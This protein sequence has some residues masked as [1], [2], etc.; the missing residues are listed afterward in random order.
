MMYSSAGSICAPDPPPDQ[1][2]TAY[3]SSV[4]S[5]HRKNVVPAARAGNSSN[6]AAKKRRPKGGMRA[7]ASAAG[8]TVQVPDAP[9]RRG[10]C[11]VA[12]IERPSV[13]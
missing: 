9:H 2:N 6:T 5:D 13:A 8:S 3:T 7:T 1:A 12:P 11:S 4:C 10:S